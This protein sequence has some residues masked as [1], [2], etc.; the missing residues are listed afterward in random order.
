MR[1][2]DMPYLTTRERDVI[3]DITQGAGVAADVA[4][5]IN[6]DKSAVPSYV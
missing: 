2:A 3:R 1:C 4:E 5:K 6:A